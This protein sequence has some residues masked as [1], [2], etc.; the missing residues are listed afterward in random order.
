M[1]SKEN[2]KFIQEAFKNFNK[3]VD[4]LKKDRELKNRIYKEQMGK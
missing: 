1:A 2:I 4:T 3:N